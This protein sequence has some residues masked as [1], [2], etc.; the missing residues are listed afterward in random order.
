MPSIRQLYDLQSVDLELDRRNARLVEIAQRLGD[1]S[2]MVPLRSETE[3]LRA[4]VAESSAGQTEIDL[5]VAG[6]DAKIA[7]AEAKLYGGK[8]TAA[9]ELQDLQADVELS[10]RQR[11]EQEDGLLVVLVELEEVQSGLA[12]ASTAL[13]EV[14]SAWLAEQ[15]SMT[16]ERG[17]LEGDV[18]AL[19]A[20]REGQANA[21][22]GPE[23]ALYEHVRKGHGGTAVARMRN[24]TCESCR[25]GVPTRQAQDVRASGKPVRCPNCGLILLA[26]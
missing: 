14:E 24:A 22:P 15:S 1:E 7:A 21:V 11:R 19:R 3:R 4:A 5:I 25:V 10:K 13:A 26:E 18:A 16:D 6:F 20:K 2:A 9:R 23:L 8:I 17:V 12:T